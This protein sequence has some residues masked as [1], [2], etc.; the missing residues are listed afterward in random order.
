MNKITISPPL[1]A[2]V[3]VS[4]FATRQ[5]KREMLDELEEGFIQRA[6]LSVTKA[7]RWYWSQALSSLGPLIRHRFEDFGIVRLILLGITFIVSV[8]TFLWWDKL[9]SRH[10]IN[11]VMEAEP[12][13]SIVN[14]RIIYF[15][16]FSIGGILTGFITG[17]IN[18]PSKTKHRIS[19]FYTIAPLYITTSTIF[20][21]NVIAS[22]SYDLIPYILFRSIVLF[23]S[24]AAG[25]KV[26]K[27]INNN[28]RR[29]TNHITNE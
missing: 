28:K 24:L 13:T 3:L 14:L 21:L 17:I 1:L 8:I 19:Y 2:I 22:G 26:F 16:T 27:L 12:G 23:I 20:I 7:K 11:I 5:F 10:V 4:L 9:V 29:I 15:I 6:T 18:N 25:I